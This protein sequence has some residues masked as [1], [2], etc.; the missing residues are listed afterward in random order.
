MIPIAEKDL[1]IDLPDGT[2]WRKF[3]DESNHGLSHCMKAVDF[4]IE[5]DDRLLFIEFKDPEHPAAKEKDQK[6][7]MS[8]HEHMGSF[9][10]FRRWRC[11]VSGRS[12]TDLIAAKTPESRHERLGRSHPA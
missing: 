4:I 7:F 5:L 11:C 2:P 9:P 6:K 8:V 1:Q 12:P 10:I 3:D